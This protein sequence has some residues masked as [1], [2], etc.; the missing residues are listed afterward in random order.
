MA[1]FTVRG[2]LPRHL[3]EEP[4][5][6]DHA[7]GSCSRPARPG[8]GASRS[9]A[10]ATARSATAS[11]PRTS[12]SSPTPRKSSS[13]TWRATSPRKSTSRSAWTTPSPRAWSRGPGTGC[14]RSTGSPSRT[15]P[16]SMTSLAVAERAPART[17]TR[18]T[19]RTTWRSSAPRPRSRVSGSTRKTT[20]RRA[21]SGALAKIAPEFLVARRGVRRPSGRPSGAPSSRSRPRARPTS[22]S[23]RAP[24]KITEGNA[25]MPFS[26]EKPKWWEMREG[27]THPGHPRRQADGGRARA[28]CPSATRTSRSSRRAP[29]GRSIDFDTC[30]KCTLCWIQ[31]PDSCFDVTPDGLYDAN[32]EACCGCG[33]CEAVCP[34]EGLHHHGAT[35]PPSTTTRASG[36]C[37]GRTRPPT[38]PG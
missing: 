7:A 22:G 26:F 1:H 13:R 19:R 16:C 9:G 18:R 28:T 23:R 6:A 38:R 24:I 36:R 10:T 20:P 30:V 8:G 3:P 2:R 14:S 34:V 33:V 12:R 27:V 32:M 31:C 21:S 37:G 35:R 25:E 5:R 15:A 11:R 29:C 4:R 17:S